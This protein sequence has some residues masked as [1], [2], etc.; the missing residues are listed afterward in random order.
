M[1]LQPGGGLISIGEDEKRRK[2][3]GKRRRSETYTMHR[4]TKTESRLKSESQPAK[5][6]AR[7]GRVPI[8]I[9]CKREVLLVFA[10]T[11]EGEPESDLGCS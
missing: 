5:A 10:V 11:F 4:H 7:P 6:H 8:Y 2:W 1:T 9:I 3:G